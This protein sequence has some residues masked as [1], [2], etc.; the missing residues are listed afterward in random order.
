MADDRDFDGNTGGLTKGKDETNTII[1]E[2][3]QA[4]V[5]METLS[6]KD[7]S[8]VVSDVDSK[9]STRSAPKPFITSTLQQAGSSKLRLSPS[10]TMRVA[11]ELY[12]EGFITYMRTDSPFLSEGATKISQ[13]IVEA[14]F[15][16]E[17]VE[18]GKLGGAKGSKARTPKNAQEAHE[19]IRPA[20]YQGSFRTPAETNL[21]GRKRALYD[22]IYRRTLASVMSKAEY[23]TRTYSIKAALERFSECQFNEVMF[24]TSERETIF[25]GFNAALWDQAAASGGNGGAG[26]GGDSALS[27]GQM[28]WLADN[29]SPQPASSSDGFEDKG[30][31]GSDSEDEDGDDADDSRDQNDE[32]EEGEEKTSIQMKS[33]LGLPR[34]TKPPNRYSESSFIKELETV[35]VGRPSTYSKVIETLRSAERKYVIV[36]GHT[37]VPTITGLIVNEFLMRHFSDLTAAEFT[38]RMEDSLDEIA[39]GKKDKLDFL[40]DYYLGGESFA[41]GGHES[42]EHADGL[43]GLLHKVKHKLVKK[44]IDHIESRTLEFPPLDGIGYLRIGSSGAYFEM[45]N[46]TTTS[47]S[48]DEEDAHQASRNRW[49]LPEAMQIDI[50]KISKGAIEEICATE[51][52]MA[53]ATVGETEEGAPV[54]IRSGRFGKFLQIGRNDEKSKKYHSLP[55]WI[56]ASTSLAHALEFST[57]PLTIGNH[58]TMKDDQGNPRAMIVEV[59]SGAV[60]VG[61]KGYPLRVEVEENLYPSQVSH[62]EAAELLSDTSAILDSQRILGTHN[63][64]EV[65]IRKGRFGYYVRCGKLIAGLRKM[66]PHEVSL[67]VAIELIETRGKEIGGG[68]K[69][70]GKAKAKPKPKPK[71]KAAK[72]KAKSIPATKKRVS[73]YIH[74]S[75]EYRETMKREN[76]DASFGTL[77]KLISQKWAGMTD[78]EKAKYKE[79]DE[80]ASTMTKVKRLPSPYIQFCKVHRPEVKLNNPDASFGEISAKLGEKWGEMSDKQKL[81]FK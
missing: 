46:S 15:G 25:A 40:S 59:S 81:E 28:M 50:R 13:A 43:D 45:E 38:A 11:Q 51:T 10:D 36:D 20:E 48:S 27:E 52:T 41:Q 8:F 78:D 19:A 60:S 62:Q 22:L 79:E 77:S 57:L 23:F 73:A 58:P 61:V 7:A 55:K 14:T 47:S 42:A 24:R 63:E 65:S 49:K 70:G 4:K 75:R 39:H 6:H 33:L 76:P 54:T 66:E 5:L 17:Y 32:G 12:E 21:E 31:D 3:G 1:L 29:F 2:K 72:S 18:T 53:G 80:A 9:K 74:F 71:A 69:R 44:E 68:K 30:G 35:G 67:E 56:E 34:T 37:L 64:E 26:S 16:D